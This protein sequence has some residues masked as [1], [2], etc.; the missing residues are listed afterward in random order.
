MLE[1]GSRSNALSDI[2]KR[3]I[4]S[5]KS[6][7]ETIIE[8]HT[9]TTPRGQDYKVT[10]EDGTIVWLNSESSLQF[11]SSF[12]GKERIVRLRGEAYFEVAKDKEHPFI[13]QTENL[14][15]KVL[16]TEFNFR[17]YPGKEAHVTLVEG[18][19]EVSSNS[20]GRIPVKIKPGED[21]FLSQNGNLNTQEVD[22]DPYIYW[23]DGYF[24]FDNVSLL[25]IMQT[26]GRWY[27]VN[28]VFN[29]KKAIDY[30]MRFLCERNSGLEHAITFMNRMKKV[31]IT[32]TDNTLYVN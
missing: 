3:S 10:L 26:I 12:T 8:I 28:I 30:K 22:V 18:S 24:Y 23:K 32:F 2:R 13:V 1:K 14:Q 9:L 21:A 7:S 6:T 4:S 16:G 31:Q 20:G 17:S 27:N 19:V 25:E 29:D 5:N 11:P 15:T